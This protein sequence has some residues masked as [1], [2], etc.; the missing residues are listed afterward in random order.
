[1]KLP[2]AHILDRLHLS[3]VPPF[4][5]FLVPEE[6]PFNERIRLTKFSR[7]DGTIIRYVAEKVGGGA[8]RLTGADTMRS[9]VFPKPDQSFRL[10]LVPTPPINRARLGNFVWCW[11]IDE[12]YFVA[13]NDGSEFYFSQQEVKIL[14]QILFPS[15][16]S[17]SATEY[18]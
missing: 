5:A 1:M 4:L 15:S 3:V 9:I 8:S 14:E 6:I 17:L 2:I 16:G 7:E 12:R 18:A 11:S 13:M 10:H